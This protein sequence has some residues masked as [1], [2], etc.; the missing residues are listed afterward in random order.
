MNIRTQFV[1]ALFNVNTQK[2]VEE[3]THK[4]AFR[5]PCKRSQMREAKAKMRAEYIREARDCKVG[6]L[7]DLLYHLKLPCNKL[8]CHLLQNF[9][10]SLMRIGSRVRLVWKELL[11][12]NVYPGNINTPQS[13]RKRYDFT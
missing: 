12:M 13:N 5:L 10:P 1:E 11:F 6:L 2:L 9:T 7:C 4:T 3:E 8:A